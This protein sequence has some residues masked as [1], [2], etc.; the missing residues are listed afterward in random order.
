MRLCTATALYCAHR[1]LVKA[2]LLSHS[3]FVHRA[4]QFGHAIQYQSHGPATPSQSC[5]PLCKPCRANRD[6]SYLPMAV[7]SD[8][9]ISMSQCARH[10]SAKLCHFPFHSHR[11][12]PP[13]PPY[14]TTIP[15]H[16]IRKHT[17]R[18]AQ[19]PFA[20]RRSRCC[21]RSCIEPAVPMQVHK[22]FQDTSLDHLRIGP[23]R[24]TCS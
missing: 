10:C 8:R 2:I 14:G 3:H 18:N 15:N 16:T 22:G 21:H 17:T 4:P 5:S 24:S 20:E 12:A 1:T 6:T 19:A 23:T 9:I 13:Y 11:I 7:P